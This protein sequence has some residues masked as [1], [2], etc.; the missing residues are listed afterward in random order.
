MFACDDSPRG[1][2]SHRSVHGPVATRCTLC[3][4]RRGTKV[5]RLWGATR[6]G[7][8]A[9]YESLQS[10]AEPR[11]LYG[12]R[13]PTMSTLSVIAW[14][15]SLRPVQGRARQV[16]ARSASAERF[17]CFF[18]PVSPRQCC[19]TRTLLRL[20]SRRAINRLGG[21]MASSSM[22]CGPCCARFCSSLDQARDQG[23][24]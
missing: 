10:R 24:N 5:R 11:Q 20:P 3:P 2:A 7:Q 6:R 23:L 22:R 21:R 8:W 19:P 18:E 17:C 12:Y 16:L 4:P 9:Y 15:L 14:V 13:A 1:H